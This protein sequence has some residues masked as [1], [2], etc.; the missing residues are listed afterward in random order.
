MQAIYL[1]LQTLDDFTTQP[2][3]GVSLWCRFVKAGALDT[4]ISVVDQINREAT[5]P[6]VMLS[7][8]TKEDWHADAAYRF[9]DVDFTSAA[10]N[11]TRSKI[12]ELL[13]IRMPTEVQNIIKRLLKGQAPALKECSPLFIDIFE[14]LDKLEQLNK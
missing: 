4:F 7:R 6:V 5:R 12:I 1:K 11:K 8:T 3:D 10:K 14:R 2:K 9:I 13:C